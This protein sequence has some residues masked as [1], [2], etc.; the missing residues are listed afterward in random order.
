MYK[1]CIILIV[2]IVVAFNTIYIKDKDKEK[3]TF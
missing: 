1:V 2:N 3:T